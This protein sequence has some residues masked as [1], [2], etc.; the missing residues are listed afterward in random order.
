M[1]DTKKNIKKDR[2]FGLIMGLLLAG[3]SAY[4]Y[5]QLNAVII[6]LMAI[7]VLITL[8]ALFI[9]RFIYPFRVGMETIGH[10]MGIVNTYILLTLI[11]IFLF[12]P[13]NLIFRLTGK[14]T[15]KLKWD[16]QTDSYWM[17]KTQQN[18]SSMKNQF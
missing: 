16:K 9:P 1:D 5:F 8:V 4:S 3:Y 14:D 7:S 11:Y 6:W 17:N 2:S 18:E 15:L 13:I 12:I 10:W